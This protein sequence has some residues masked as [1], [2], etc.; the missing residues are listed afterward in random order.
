MTTQNESRSTASVQDK[1]GGSSQGTLANRAHEVADEARQATLDRV[2]AARARAQAAKDE[3]AEGVRKIGATVRKVGEHLRVEDQHYIGG[4]AN[5]LSQ[6]LDD[7]AS[8]LSSAELATL[9]RD[10]RML[11]RRSP[12]WFYGGAFVLGLA[13]GR[14]LKGGADATSYRE[15]ARGGQPRPAEKRIPANVRGAESSRIGAT[16]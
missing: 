6:R 13:A 10:T 9:A 3:A 15:P 11:A 12:G 2:E 14:F 7:V 4:K 16:R 1:D 5:D 8:Y